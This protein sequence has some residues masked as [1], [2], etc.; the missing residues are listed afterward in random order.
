MICL[1]ASILHIVELNW[2]LEEQLW[3]KKC[4]I[5]DVYCKTLNGNV[6]R[7]G[8]AQGGISIWI[9]PTAHFKVKR[10]LF[11][12]LCSLNVQ[13]CPSLKMQVLTGLLMSTSFECEIV[14]NDLL[15]TLPTHPP[16]TTSVPCYY[17]QR[18]VITGSSV[19]SGF[20]SSRD[21]L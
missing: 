14:W 6:R 1:K 21:K 10:D 4:L 2:Q 9:N 11:F 7:G 3:L 12:P 15:L 20:E 19:L 8:G 16:T 5:W 13:Y 18:K 17:T